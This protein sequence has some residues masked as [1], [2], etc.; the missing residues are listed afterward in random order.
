[1]EIQDRVVSGRSSG[2]VVFVAVLVVALAMLLVA[3]LVT[4]GVVHQRTTISTSRLPAGS[5][6]VHQQA[7][8]AAERNSVYYAALCSGYDDASPDAR[9][10]NI[11]LSGC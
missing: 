7:P 5:A 10:R 11:A 2:R 3:A 6:L 9:D 1:V 4:E 8:D